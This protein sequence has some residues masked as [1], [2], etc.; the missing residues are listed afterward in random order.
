MVPRW[1]QEFPELNLHVF[2][3]FD[4]WKKAVKHRNNPA[5][6]AHMEEVERG[7]QQP[8]V[9]YHGRVSQKQLADEQMKS[10]FW[11]YPTE[12]SETSC[13]TAMECMLAGAI[14]VCTNYAALETT[15]PSDCGIKVPLDNIKDIE[16][17]TIDLIKNKELQKKYRA[18]G[19]KH[20]IA[21]CGW[22]AVV[23]SW[24]KM[25]EVT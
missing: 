25:F 2:Y 13:I 24:I 9:V 3:G 19:E 8:G 20:V 7:L 6:I 16:E 4:N 23:D 18:A 1:R 22:D 12:F 17:K 10:S 21:T 14:P 11:V 5:E 15:V